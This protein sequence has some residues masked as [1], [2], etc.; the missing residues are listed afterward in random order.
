MAEEFGCSS[1]RVCMAPA[2]TVVVHVG[3]GATTHVAGVARCGSVG[4]CPVCAPTI[5]QARA[6]DIDAAAEAWTALGHETYL[7]TFTIPHGVEDDP[8]DLLAVLGRMWRQMREGQAFRNWRRDAAVEGFI[9]AVEI[10]YGANGWHPHLHV[11]FF[12]KRRR[13][14]PARLA[15]LWRTRFELE[16]WSY[17]PK[18]SCDVRKLTRKGI[19][20][21][22]GKINQGWGAG[23]E[24][25]RADL[26]SRSLSPADLLDLAFEEFAGLDPASVTTGEVVPWD[27]NP[28]ARWLLRW[29]ELERATKGLRW[30]EWGKGLRKRAGGWQMQAIVNGHQLEGKLLTVEEASDQEAAR[31]VDADQVVASWHVPGPVWLRFRAAGQLGL[32]LQALISND[33]ERYGAW[34]VVSWID[35]DWRP[36]SGPSRASPVPLLASS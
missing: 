8:G 23:A 30:I 27:E 10:T 13:M 34:R 21:Y 20:V 32:L 33:G 11:L 19:G 36:R 35:P 4:L 26:K 3:A 15:E 25:A 1:A 24:L 2:S 16:G 7:A 29:A 31:G 17:V 9:K 22:L 28:A 12:S 6:A 5:R 18:V 14:L